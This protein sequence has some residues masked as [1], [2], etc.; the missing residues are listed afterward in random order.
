MAADNPTL[1]SEGRGMSDRDMRGR[2][3]SDRDM[4]GRVLSD[5]D[6]QE[7]ANA[8]IAYQMALR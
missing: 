7:A 1:N 4:R 5:R 8:A 3:L 2:V 6:L